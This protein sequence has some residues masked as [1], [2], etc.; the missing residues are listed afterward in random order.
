VFREFARYRLHLVGVKRLGGERGAIDEYRIIPLFME[1][2]I[3]T[4]MIFYTQE[5]CIVTARDYRLL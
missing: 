3:K 2:E 4:K 5:N 1:K